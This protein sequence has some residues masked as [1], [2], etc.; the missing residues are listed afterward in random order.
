MVF[1]VGPT[2]TVVQTGVLNGEWR[3]YGGDLGSTKYLSIDQIDRDN[4]GDF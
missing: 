1:G 3:Y 2:I 4:V